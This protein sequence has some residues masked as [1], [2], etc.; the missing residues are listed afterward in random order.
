MPE[1]KSKN[2]L[3][4]GGAGF[5]GSHTCVE[6]LEQGMQV[7]IV[8]NLD[9]SNQIALDRIFKITGKKPIFFK[10]DICNEKDLEGVFK[11]SPKFD[12]CIHFAGLKAVGESCTKPLRYYS[13]NL[14]GTLYL[15]NLM[16]K[17]DCCSIIFSSSATVYGDPHKLPIT[18][19]FPLQPTNP[20]GRTKA[21]IEDMLRDLAKGESGKRWKVVILRYFNPIGAH[22]SGLIGEDPMG[23]PNNLMPYL[24][25]VAVGR[26]KELTIF[27]SDYETKDGTGVR[28]Y[29][30]VV[31]LA[32]GHA[33]ALN[34]GIF[35]EGMNSNCE[36]YNLGTGNGISVLEM[37]KAMSKACGRDLPYKMGERRSGDVAAN[38]AD[39]TKAATQL[40][41]TCKLGVDRMCADTWRWQSANPKGYASEGGGEKEGK[42]VVVF[43]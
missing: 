28:D 38:Y 41:F 24:A 14:I 21:M 27:G 40:K 39:G 7:T 1:N 33:A 29:I 35:G 13:N 31:D 12:A 16:E 34:E 43:Q 2:I 36:V 32:K 15:L 8:D 42:S 3:V 9:N 26:R 17:Y 19:D 20:Y 25:Q 4:T 30:H 10:V 11:S 37:L 18:E 23:I 22:E 5:I 6:L